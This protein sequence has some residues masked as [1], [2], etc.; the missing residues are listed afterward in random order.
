MEEERRSEQTQWQMVTEGTACFL[1]ESRRISGDWRHLFQISVTMIEAERQSELEAIS[2]KANNV[3]DESL[4]STRRM[5][6]LCE[7]VRNWETDTTHDMTKNKIVHLWIFMNE[8]RS[9]V[10]NNDLFDASHLHQQVIMLSKYSHHFPHATQILYLVK[11][12]G[13]QN[14]GRSRW[15]RR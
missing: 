14:F 7:E 2:M 6:A 8:I 11:R 3:V 10:C 12:G 13:D 4:E 5:L 15:S 9:L 1:T